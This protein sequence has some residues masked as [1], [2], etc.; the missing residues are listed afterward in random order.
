[1]TVGLYGGSFNPAHSGHLHVA[2]TARRRLGLDGVVWLVSPQNPLKA[3]KDTA[4]LERRIQGV[5]KLAKAPGNIVSDVESRAGV[6]YT[7]DT[8]RLLKARFPEVRFVW[9]MG[10]DSLATF[11]RWKGWTD[12]AREV[13]I[14]V[15]ARPGASLRAHLSPAA[16]RFPAA[17]KPAAAAAAFGQM[18]PPAWIYLNAPLNFES[19]TQLRGRE[20]SGE[21]SLPMSG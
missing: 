5:V 1:M 6:Q 16:R 17:R 19:S 18:S 8:V 13:P 20:T 15:V 14:C 3:K 12:I 11:H 2:K 21:S 4:A 7:I 9:I 10:A